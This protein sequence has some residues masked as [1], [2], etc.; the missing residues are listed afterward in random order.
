MI[1]KIKQGMLLLFACSL[2]FT[3]CSDDEPAEGAGSRMAL[4]ENAVMFIQGASSK[5]VAVTNGGEWTVTVPQEAAS[6]CS[7]ERNGESLIVTVTENTASELRETVLTV[8]GNELKTLPVRQTGTAPVIRVTSYNLGEEDVD[9]D[10]YIPVGYTATDLTVNIVTNVPYETVLPAGSWIAV[11]SQ[12]EPG[13]DG[14][15]TVALKV[16]AYENDKYDRDMEI[17]FKQKEGDYYQLLSVKQRKNIGTAFL[18]ADDMFAVEPREGALEISW[19]FPEGVEYSKVIFEYDNKKTPIEDDKLTIEVGASEERK[20]L[21]N[22]LY[23]KYG[24][25]MFKVD[26]L[27]KDGESLVY[28]EGGFV[29]NAGQCNPVQP[30]ITVIEREI[31]L[32]AKATDSNDPDGLKWFSFSGI[33]QWGGKYEYLVDNDLSDGNHWESED[34]KS[35]GKEFN[36]IIIQIP[37]NVEC[38]EFTIKTVNAIGQIS[39]APGLYTVSIGD[40]DDPYSNDWE[41]VFEQKEKEWKYG[42]YYYEVKDIATA[43]H[44]FEKKPSNSDGDK[45]RY[46]TLPAMKSQ[47]DGKPVKYIRYAVTDRNNDAARNDNFKLAEL[48]LFNI[49]VDRYD[50]ENE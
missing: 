28:N 46:K 42:N 13:A 19:N 37:D 38:T 31:L 14:R 7:A 40:S 43:E 1:N 10:G 9:F 48:K 16:A 22:E 11:V 23:A 36:Y 50:P 18:L 30:T 21:V 49:V 25:M 29:L 44:D 39:Q 17:T 20:I 5:E 41:V 32:N 27:N 4:S 35:T 12:S 24:D 26:V 33:S 47:T 6:W 15:A 34:R 45:Y 3:A 2:S 8:K